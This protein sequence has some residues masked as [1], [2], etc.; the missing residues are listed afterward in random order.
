VPEGRTFQKLNDFLLTANWLRL[1]KIVTGCDILT[2][3]VYIKSS[4]GHP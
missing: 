4:G 2:F 3:T 1:E